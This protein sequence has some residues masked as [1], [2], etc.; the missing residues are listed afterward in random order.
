MLTESER[1]THR[2]GR[3]TFLPLWSYANPLRHDGDELCDVLVIFGE[4]VLIFSVKENAYK[5]TDDVETG[6]D[7]WYRKA[8]RRSVVQITGAER[9][10]KEP[11]NTRVIKSDKTEGVLIPEN[12]RIHRI[13][14]A[15][16]SGGQL[17][18]PYGEVEGV[19]AHV[20]DEPS[21]FHVL[22]ELDTA[23]DFI[24]YLVEKDRIL[25]VRPNLRIFSESDLLAAY[26]SHRRSLS[27]LDVEADEVILGDDWWDTHVRSED[28]RFRDEDNKISY[29]WDGI[30]EFLASEFDQGVA[31]LGVSP[32]DA[33]IALRLLAMPNRFERRTLATDFREIIIDP[34]P[35]GINSMKRMVDHDGADFDCVPH[36]YV[37]LAVDPEITR[38]QRRSALQ[39][40]CWI[41]RW[42][43]PENH[44]VVGIATEHADFGGPENFEV[45]SLTQ[46][47]LTPD[48][49]A[50]AKELQGKTG[51]FT[52]ITVSG[53]EQNE[54]RADRGRWRIDG[55]S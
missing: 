48:F 37:F 32:D 17:L 19:T 54:F 43:R 9:W 10:L 25:S 49:V 8:I 20:F 13:A 22:S 46:E 33:E 23:A 27:F 15:F 26:I 31:E 4:D 36:T 5:P 52:N 24:A 47:E 28:I 21:L 18:L 29:L 1:I 50:K 51:F 55:Q 2:L 38:E 14:V 30:I 40:M 12:P 6:L 34:L 7:R 39:A 41:A 45:V 3:N 44:T 42:L 11:T 16:G 53:Q 35:A